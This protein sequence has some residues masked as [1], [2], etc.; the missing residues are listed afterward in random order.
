VDNKVRGATVPAEESKALVLRIF[1]L[2]FGGEN[3][4]TAGG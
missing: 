2:F 3:Q 1:D 4:D